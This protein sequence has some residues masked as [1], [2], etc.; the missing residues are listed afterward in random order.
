[1]INDHEVMLEVRDGD[2]EKLG[3]LFEKHNKHLYNFFLRQTGKGQESEDL[4]QEVF[5][6]ML[7]YRHTYKDEGDFMVWMFKIAYNARNDYYKKHRRFN[8]IDDE[9]E[10]LASNDPLPDKVT[11]QKSEIEFLEKALNSLP[12]EK[13]EL[14]LMS[15]YENINY[16]DIGNILGCTEGTVKVRMYRAMKELTDIYFDLTGGKCYEM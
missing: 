13:K 15:R 2:V 8:N 6:R 16:K 12:Q 10:T 3:L 1:M 7:K 5:F 9:I 11:E 4:T 14:I